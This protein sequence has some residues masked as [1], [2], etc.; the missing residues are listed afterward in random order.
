MLDLIKPD[1]SQ[2]LN[3]TEGECVAGSRMR[4][5]LNKLL[6][7]GYIGNYMVASQNRGTPIYTLIYYSPYYGGPQNGT[8]NLRKPPYR[9]ARS[10]DN[11]SSAVGCSHQNGHNPDSLPCDTSRFYTRAHEAVSTELHGRLLA[12]A[13]A[14]RIQPLGKQLGVHALKHQVR[15]PVEYQYITLVRK[16]DPFHI[17]R[18]S[19]APQK[20]QRILTWSQNQ[21]WGL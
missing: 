6:E 2:L 9:G 19:P 1:M 18:R 8:P 13:S 3:R 14:F 17:D 21:H 7:G 12:L 15:A 20:V 10:L 11:S 5:N 4:C 16:K